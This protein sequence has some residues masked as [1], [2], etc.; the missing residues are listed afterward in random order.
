MSTE[1]QSGEKSPN[2]DFVVGKIAFHLDQ[3]WLNAKDEGKASDFL[4]NHKQVVEALDLPVELW[5]ERTAILGRR[6]PSL[7]EAVEETVKRLK[8]L[9]K[10]SAG[11][12]QEVVGEI[13]G[14]SMSYGRFYNVRGGDNPSDIDIILVVDP[15]FFSFEE[16]P[17]RIV[18]SS[19]GFQSEEGSL[20]VQRCLNFQNL[21]AIGEAQMLSQKFSIEDYALSLK[22][23]PLP[24]FLWEFKVVPE[25]LVSQR[26][27][28]A[29]SIMDYK[30]APYSDKNS[31]RKSFF[32]DT[33]VFHAKEKILPNGEAITEVPVAVF[34]DGVLY[35]GDHHNHLLPKFEVYADESGVV[36]RVVQNFEITLRKEFDTESAVSHNG[37]RADLVN[38]MDRLPFLQA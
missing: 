25:G 30:P 11:L 9:E 15:S 36:S 26:A 34:K 37:R 23:I 10:F 17:E 2:L 18:D 27:N 32:A 12:P 13:C 35:T 28:R 14:G 31:P 3:A 21:Y 22:V 8:F 16:I 24:N 7:G 5:Q 4:D 33:Y 38:S 19:L 6:Q 29:V 1:R 20:F